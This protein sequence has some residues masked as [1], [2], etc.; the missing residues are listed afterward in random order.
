MKP[1]QRKIIEK[2]IEQGGGSDFGVLT[3]AEDVALKAL[4]A[5]DDKRNLSVELDEGKIRGAIFSCSPLFGNADWDPSKEQ[6][7]IWLSN[8]TVDAIAKAIKDAE[9]IRIGG[10]V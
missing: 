7:E 2:I 6:Y 8:K 3:D 4:L 9:C 5:E 10:K 1:E